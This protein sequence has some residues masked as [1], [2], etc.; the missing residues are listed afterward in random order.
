MLDKIVK[1]LEK[2][3]RCFC[4]LDRWQPERETWHTLV[5]PIHKEAMRLQADAARPGEAE[6]LALPAAQLKHGS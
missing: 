1:E 6:R 3:M 2:S 5:C 4:D